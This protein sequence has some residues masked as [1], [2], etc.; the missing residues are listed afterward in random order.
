MNSTDVVLHEGQ[1]RDMQIQS[2]IGNDPTEADRPWGR[3]V[4]RRAP[5]RVRALRHHVRPT[6]LPR[7]AE[8]AAAAILYGDEI[9]FTPDAG[10][11]EPL[12]DRRQV[13]P[14]RPSDG[15]PVQAS[16]TDTPCGPSR[17]PTSP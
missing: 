7:Q 17:S 5:H 13:R 1:H 9:G 16:V 15:R 12:R 4:S 2:P 14:L 3:S 8:E 6:A 11:A 10:P